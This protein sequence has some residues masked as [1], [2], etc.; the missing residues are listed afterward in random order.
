MFL[1]ANERRIPD[2]P[3][4]RWQRAAELVRC[5]NCKDVVREKVGIKGLSFKQFS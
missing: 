5:R 4:Y 1:I 2:H 3:V